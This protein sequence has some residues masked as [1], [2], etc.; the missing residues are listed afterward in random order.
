[1]TMIRKL[2]SVTFAGML[3]A[4]TLGAAPAMAEMGLSPT[5]PDRMYVTLFGGYV[6]SDGTATPGYSTNVAPFPTFLFE[7]EHGGFG[8]VTAGYVLGY[9]MPFGLENFRI[10]A[11]F[12]ASLF[13][14]DEGSSPNGSLIDLDATGMTFGA[15]ES[16]QSRK[17][18]DWSVV[19]KGDRQLTPDLGTA[20]G[21][22]LF[23]RH[24]EDRTTTANPIFGFRNH[25]VDGFFGG[26]MA[27][28]QPEYAFT[29]ALSFVANLGAGLYGV[30]A[31]AR[32]ITNIGP[33]LTFNDSEGTVGFRARAKGG[34]RLK[35]TDAISLTLF[36]G[37]DYWSDVP[38]A[39]QTR[40]SFIIG[41]DPLPELKFTDLVE[42]KAGLTLTVLLGGP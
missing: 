34:L 9:P 33:P 17:V 32:S 35:A 25:D 19:L 14:D 24:N 15:V 26:V 10:E 2:K 8:G 21:I 23:F 28:V 42:L 18:Y 39:D 40:G 3:A 36:G 16:R 5:G 37:V 22:E 12:A 4:G 29:P 20:F 27:V 31:E 11:S 1:M 41:P 13:D 7:A 38:V 6:N 30:D